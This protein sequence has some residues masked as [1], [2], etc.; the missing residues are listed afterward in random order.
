MH[1]MCEHRR[2]AVEPLQNARTTA[3]KGSSLQP[4]KRCGVLASLCLPQMVAGSNVRATR[5][6]P[7]RNSSVREGRAVFSPL[8]PGRALLT[9]RRGRTRPCL[10]A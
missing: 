4:R 1:Y 6:T 3:S 7:P 8:H 5:E 2:R 10:G 9:R